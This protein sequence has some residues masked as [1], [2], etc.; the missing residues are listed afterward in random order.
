MYDI[1]LKIK[2]YKFYIYL[3]SLSTSSYSESRNPHRYTNNRHWLFVG[4][5]TQNCMILSPISLL[6]MTSFLNCGHLS[7][8]PASIQ[9]MWLRSFL[10]SW[11][12]LFAKEVLIWNVVDWEFITHKKRNKNNFISAFNKIDISHEIV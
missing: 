4:I 9:F 6:F 3:K 11:P 10:K 12:S 2:I 1:Q 5:R 7:S 8:K